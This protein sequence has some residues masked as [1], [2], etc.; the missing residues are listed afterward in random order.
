MARNTDADSPPLAGALL[1]RVLWQAA[2]WNLC[3]FGLVLVALDSVSSSRLLGL[4]FLTLHLPQRRW[5]Q[6]VPARKGR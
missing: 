4:V 1:H 3:S 5:G 2:G 6:A